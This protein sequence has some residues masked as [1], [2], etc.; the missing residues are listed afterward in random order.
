[1]SL[2]AL[3][4]TLPSIGSTHPSP[5]PPMRLSQGNDEGC[6]LWLSWLHTLL[7]PNTLRLYCNEQSKAGS[8]LHLV[9][10]WPDAGVPSR[11]AIDKLVARAC[12]SG[13]IV[14]AKSGVDNDHCVVCVP[15]PVKGRQ[16][17]SRYVL[18]VERHE[19][20]KLDFNTQSR[21]IS[22]AFGALERYASAAVAEPKALDASLAQWS[23]EQLDH[24]GTLSDVFAQLMLQVSDATHSQRC[25]MV[26]FTHNRRRIRRPQLVAMSGQSR[27]DCRLAEPQAI[28]RQVHKMYDAQA[29]TLRCERSVAPYVVDQLSS[30]LPHPLCSRLTLPLHTDAGWYVVSIERAADKPFD[31]QEQVVLNREL[32]AALQVLLLCDSSKSSITTAIKRRLVG[33]TRLFGESI[34]RTLLFCAAS[35]LSALLFFYPVEYRITAP[36]SV[37]AAE[38]HVL[39]APVDGFLRSVQVKA[40]DTVEKNQVMASLDDLDL[41]L[42]WQQR[43][44]ELMLNQQAYATALATRNR[45]E[46]THLKESAL[47][48]HAELFQ[49]QAQKDRLVLK[50][51]VAGVV[52]SGTLD[53]FLGA[54]VSAGDTLF[55]I[56]SNTSHRLVLSVSEYDVNSVQPG[57]SVGI[58]LSANPSTVLTAMVTAIMPLAAPLNG[59]NSVQVHAKL[60]QDVLLRPGMEGLGKVLVG[61][62]G[63]LSQWLSRASARLVWLGWNLGVVR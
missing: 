51:P 31:E 2:P 13:S 34:P 54:A 36:L 17:L 62:Q 52:L 14:R 3:D 35:V 43:Q 8:H 27:I 57:Q 11:G 40:G 46:V 29:L 49:L 23:A 16:C 20:S 33:F 39:I 7:L 21:L 56:G 1:M 4:T 28:A 63:R 22:W 38:R 37:E 6:R 60:E 59:V 5:V 18:V 9:A 42:Q 61:R 48:I 47:L 45:V 30:E 26:K 55:S 58:R 12:K 32:G 25:I 41:Q 44:S 19:A 24:Q 53:D 50:A 15:E 10:S